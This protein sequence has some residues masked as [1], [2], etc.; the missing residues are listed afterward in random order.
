MVRGTCFVIMPFR[1]ELSYL[2]RFLKQHVEQTFEIRCER[3]DDRV[4]TTPLLDKIKDM[5]ANADACL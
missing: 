4:L 1:P 5:I 2:Y 3:A